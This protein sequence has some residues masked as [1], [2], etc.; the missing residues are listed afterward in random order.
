MGITMV[1]AA[2]TVYLRDVEYI[3]GIL[4]MAWQFLTPVMYSVEMVP[5]KLQKL[6]YLN[7]MTPIV[8]AY[9]KILYEGEVPQLSTLVSGAV[10]G[11]IILVF[12]WILFHRLQRHFVEEL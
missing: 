1:V 8:I 11:I 10:M 2:I 5:E 3:L 6:F 7:P 9:R 4:T 12:G